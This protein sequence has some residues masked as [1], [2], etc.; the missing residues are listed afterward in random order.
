MGAPHAR[1][2]G[3]ADA[4]K[5]C[6][7]VGQ[8]AASQTGRCASVCS[9]RLRS[10]PGGVSG[11]DVPSQL[12]QSI[13]RWPEVGRAERHRFHASVAGREPGFRRRSRW[14]SAVCHVARLRRSKSRSLAGHRL[15]CRDPVFL[16][17]EKNC[18]VYGRLIGRGDHQISSS[19]SSSAKARCCQVNLPSAANSLTSAI[20]SG[21]MTRRR[22][23]RSKGK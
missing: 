14:R 11:Y 20:A 19:T 21:A 9:K 17:S 18:L 16:R 13:E 15:S 8:V 4:G 23:R 5:A 12:A 22:R 10:S 1:W 7:R 2:F 3:S 6:S